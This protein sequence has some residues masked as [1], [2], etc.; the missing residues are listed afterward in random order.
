MND[1]DA[2]IRKEVAALRDEVRRLRR[3]M[4]FITGFGFGLIVF[5]LANVA[6]HFVHSSPNGRT[7]RVLVYGFPFAVWVEGGLPRIEGDL[8]YSAAS[9]DVAIGLFCAAGVGVLCV[10]RSERERTV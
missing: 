4:G 3:R 1:S 9:A 5:A 6:S 10:R 2:Q 7:E 8:N